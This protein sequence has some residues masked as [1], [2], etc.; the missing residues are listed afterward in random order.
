MPENQHVTPPPQLLDNQIVTDITLD[1]QAVTYALIDNRQQDNL[2]HR[3][4]IFLSFFF[5]KEG[6][7]LF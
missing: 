2:L 5:W 3:I 7:F 6:N 4:L 1:S